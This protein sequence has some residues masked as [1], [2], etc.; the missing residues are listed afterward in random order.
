[1]DD[2]PTTAAAQSAYR[3]PG[4]AYTIDRAVHLTRLSAFYPACV[5]C[6]HR[7]DTGGLSPV[8]LRNR[9]Q[10]ESRVPGGPRL[11][12]EAI[13]GDAAGDVDTEL[14]ARLAGSLAAGLWTDRAA[15][16]G[17][18]RVL[19]GTD[20]HWA[21]A[22]FVPA[23]CRGLQ[24]SGCSA[25]EVGAVTAPALACAAGR[26][27]ADAAM[28]IGHRDGRPHALQV[29]LWQSAGRPSSSPGRLD[30]VYEQQTSPYVRARRSG[31]ASG[32]VDAEAIYLPSL[33]GMFHGLRPLAFV[34]DTACRPWLRYWQRLAAESACRLL[35]PATVPIAAG[36]ASGDESHRRARLDV[37]AATVMAEGAHFGIW[38]DGDGESCHLIDERG[39]AV[40]CGRLLLLLAGHLCPRQ[41][42]PAIVLEPECDAELVAQLEQIGARV[43]RSGP[44]R[45]QIAER[46][47]S[48]AAVA[49]GGASGRYWF[50]GAPPAPDALAC[51]SLLVRILS[52]SD[53]PLSEVLDAGPLGV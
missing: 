2:L 45:E 6:E 27:R 19:V 34:V 11:T 32:R 29:K 31:G 30:A 46:M 42:E 16:S 44:T 40:P 51:L 47:E 14:I 1:M 35:S 10:V 3:C 38:I 33:A 22:D 25:L 50:G 49:G 37:V 41:T 5:R 23:A 20:G 36:S 18:P 8:Q 52:Q 28:W 12:S 4:Q 21:T 26:L 13:A 24:L 39:T 9:A 7:H 53:R 43:H 48:T 17:P 15:A